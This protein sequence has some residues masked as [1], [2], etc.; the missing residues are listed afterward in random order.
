MKTAQYPGT[1]IVVKHAIVH[2]L[3]DFSTTMLFKL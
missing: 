3:H 1:T 2:G